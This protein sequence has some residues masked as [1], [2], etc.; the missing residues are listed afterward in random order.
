MIGLDP[1]D[2][3]QRTNADPD[4]ETTNVINVEVEMTV[5]MIEEGVEISLDA[6][7]GKNKTVVASGLIHL[8]RIMS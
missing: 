1:T 3:V 4:L 8:L 5:E 6:E 7:M 2:V